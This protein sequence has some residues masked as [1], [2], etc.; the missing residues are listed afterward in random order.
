MD[1]RSLRAFVE[2]VRQGGFSAAAKTVF[3]T[4]PTISKA[5]KQLEDE[6][7]TPL[8]DRVGH[9]VS[10]TAAGDLV[11]RRAAVMLAER[12][13]LRQDLAELLG[14]RRG[15]LR[16]GLARLG[17][18]IMF[19]TVVAEFHRRHPDIELELV[20]HGSL[21]LSDILL[22]GELDLAMCMLPIPEGLDWQLVHDEPLMILLPP[23]HPLTGRGS[24][25]LADLADSP[26]ILFESGF[27]LNPQILAACQRSGFTPRVVAYSGQADFIQSLVAAGL[28]VAFLP[29]V[30]VAGGVRPPIACVAL[31]DADLRWRI[32][33][34][35]RRE[36]GLA[37]AAAAYLALVRDVLEAAPSGADA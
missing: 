15:R 23:G 31:D 25:G 13:N 36:A 9:R 21:H 5:V 4:Q 28:G 24:V 3:A 26:F 33:L 18:A 35:W 7:G 12:D 22:R 29:R 30:I 17:S 27:A 1:L 8:L 34:A 10:L 2:V 37:P 11:Y 19:G 14:L 16:L 6:L 20:E 32:T